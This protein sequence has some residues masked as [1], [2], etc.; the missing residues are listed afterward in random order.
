VKERKVWQISRFLQKKRERLQVKRWRQ[1]KRGKVLEARK[2]GKNA[3]GKL[4]ESLRKRGPVAKK[5]AIG[6]EK[7]L[8]LDDTPS[9]DPKV[10]V[11]TKTSEKKKKREIA[12]KASKLYQRGGGGGSAPPKLCPT[13]DEKG[14]DA[15]TKKR[16][17]KKEKDTCS[18]GKKE[19]L[20]FS[21]QKKK[22]RISRMTRRGTYENAQTEQ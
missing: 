6:K 1:R 18:K 7:G 22:K 10:Q 5:G 15:K 9:E 12:G 14:K 13:K 21:E 19:D 8:T 17:K 2:Q 16:E 4:L 11:L 20:D 3:G